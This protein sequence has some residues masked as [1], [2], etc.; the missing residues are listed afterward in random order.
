MN[1]RPCI[2]FCLYLYYLS[3]ICTRNTELY[4]IY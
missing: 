2:I 1:I 3:S 4:F